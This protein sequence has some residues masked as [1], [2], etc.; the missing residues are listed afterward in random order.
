MQHCSENSQFRSLRKL[1]VTGASGFIGRGI[2]ERLQLHQE[3]N[4]LG[5]TRRR[6]AEAPARQLIPLSDRSSVQAMRQAVAGCEAVIHTAGMA[7]QS[8]GQSLAVYRRINSEWTRSLVEASADEG[9]KHFIFLSSAGVF[10]RFSQPGCPFGA[11]DSLAPLEDYAISKM[12]AEDVIRELAERTR[13]AATIIRPPLVYGRSAPGNFRRLVAAV[14]SGIPLPLA[15]IDNQRSFVGL[16]NLVDLVIRCLEVPPNGV[17]TLLV[18][19]DADIST[20]SLVLLIAEALN[21][22]VRL[23]SVRPHRLELI[24]R[25]IGREAMA[26]QLC[27]SFQLDVSETKRMLAWRPPVSCSEVLR[28]ALRISLQ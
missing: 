7:H 13:I 8:R 1:L 15:A 25:L 10:G 19:D 24:A 16:P 27:R 9:V 20:P 11:H 18:S 4:V 12:E 5:A 22:Q 28:A 21:R 26:I 6:V 2:I 17:R 3:W 14:G 23:Y